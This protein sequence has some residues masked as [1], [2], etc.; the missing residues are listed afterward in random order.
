M[1]TLEAEG[2][3][4]AAGARV[5]PARTAAG[6]LESRTRIGAGTSRHIPLVRH[7]DL[8]REAQR[9]HQGIV[10]LRNA[11]VDEIHIHLEE[12]ACRI[13]RHSGTTVRGKCLSI[14]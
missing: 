10:D 6:K 1:I 7:R 12:G 2:I 14:Q 5:L 13:G 4:R 11:A 9:N 8:L 3:D